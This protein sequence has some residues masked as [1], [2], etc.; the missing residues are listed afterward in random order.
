MNRRKVGW[1][2]QEAKRKMKVHNA[3]ENRSRFGMKNAGRRD[4][5]W[6]R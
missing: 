4:A 1:E 5:P 6:K 2:H 3:T